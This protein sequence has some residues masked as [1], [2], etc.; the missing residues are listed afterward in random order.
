M[1]TM[2]K[3]VTA[4]LVVAVAAAALSFPAAPAQDKKDKG[5]DAGKASA[6]FEL[7]KD[8]GGEFRFRI[9]DEAGTMLAISGKGYDDKAEVLKVIDHIKKTATNAKLDDQTAKK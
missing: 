5:K 7:Y 6:V 8:K 2:F 9:K 4:V 3:R 1:A